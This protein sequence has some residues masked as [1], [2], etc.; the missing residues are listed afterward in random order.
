MQLNSFQ[1]AYVTRNLDHAVETVRKTHGLDD[2]IFFDPDIEV[3]TPM[4]TGRAQVRVASAWAGTT[5]IEIIQPVGGMIDLY[6][7]YLPADDTLRFH[8]SAVRIDDWGTFRTQVA[9]S[10]WTVAYESGL[11]GLE[12][13]YLDA[14]ETLG[15]Y[16]EYM[17]CTPEWWQALGYP[18]ERV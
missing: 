11:D 4:G 6:L 1:N 7:P 18:A 2:F 8:H 9:S 5:Q 16:V 14:R 3:R 12:F 13:V 17:W 10:G 15:H